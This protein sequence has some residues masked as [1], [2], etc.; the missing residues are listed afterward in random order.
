[1]VAVG[2]G[3]AKMSRKQEEREVDRWSSQRSPGAGADAGSRSDLVFAGLGLA[4][5]TFCA[6][7]PW[8]VF[9]NQ[10]QF[11]IRAL[12]FDGRVGVGGIG[13]GAERVA[14]AA[15]ALVPLDP[16]MTGTLPDPRRPLPR[17]PTDR[18]Q[19]LPAAG[20]TVLPL[21]VSTP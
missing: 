15:T 20:R 10:D 1:M 21:R 6:V 13:W 19:P 8:Y 18:E 16:L 3:F 11:G 5:G 12:V 7:L 14:E 2:V 4:L 9:F 17:Q